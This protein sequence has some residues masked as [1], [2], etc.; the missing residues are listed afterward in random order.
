MSPRKYRGRTAGRFCRGLAALGC[1]FANIAAANAQAPVI[2]NPGDLRTLSVNTV[3]RAGDLDPAWKVIAPMPT[4]RSGV[5]TAAANGKVYA[6]GGGVLDDCTTVLTVEAYDPV[7]DVWITELAPMLPPLVTG[8]PV[9]RSTTL[10]IWLVGR[11]WTFSATTRPSVQSRHTTPRQTA[12]LTS[13][14]C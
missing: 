4:A 8:Q 5:A 12:G 13:N 1:V 11:R 3:F 7:R 9:A 2:T 14:P 10:F 6:M